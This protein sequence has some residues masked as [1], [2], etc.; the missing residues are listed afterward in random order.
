M[1]KKMNLFILILVFTSNYTFGANV[2]DGK[3]QVFNLFA[4]LMGEDQTE[5]P[6]IDWN[7]ITSK[8]IIKLKMKEIEIDEKEL[9]QKVKECVK[10]CMEKSR[11]D[12]L[13]RDNCI[14][15]FCDIY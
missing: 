5:L 15:K 9:F 8:K 11:P 6:E 14:A 12:R 2:Y 4:S 7:A 1:F 3:R 13:Y 10:K